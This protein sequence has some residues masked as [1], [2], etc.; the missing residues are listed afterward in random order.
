MRGCTV[1]D[2]LAC[3]CWGAL[4][5]CGY[6]T[7]RTPFLGFLLFF[8]QRKS[9][10]MSERLASTA[11]LTKRWQPCCALVLALLWAC[12]QAQSTCEECVSSNMKWVIDAQCQP[13]CVDTSTTNDAYRSE[14]T[15]CV[16]VSECEYRPQTLTQHSRTGTVHGTNGAQASLLKG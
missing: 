10:R 2:L 15:D 3:A 16:N 7:K 5:V 11:R 1:A 12:A 6:G 13:H 8:V 9:Y 14:T 4:C